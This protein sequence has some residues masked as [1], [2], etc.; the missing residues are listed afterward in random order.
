M[1]D[2]RK[3]KWTWVIVRYWP[4]NES[5]VALLHEPYNPTYEPTDD[6]VEYDDGYDNSY[7]I[8]DRPCRIYNG[9]GSEY[10]LVSYAIVRITTTNAPVWAD[11]V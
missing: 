7:G 1:P 8:P 6:F 3:D 9:K 2:F 11:K 4:R 10:T 5:I